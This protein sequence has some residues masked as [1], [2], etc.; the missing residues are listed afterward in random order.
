MRCGRKES[1]ASQVMINFPRR[2]E[3]ACVVKLLCGGP[4]SP[5]AP[6]PLKDKRGNR[7]TR[8]AVGSLLGDPRALPA[9]AL[10]HPFGVGPARCASKGG[11][12]RSSQSALA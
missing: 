12:G 8:R 3:K 1:K 4:S 11:G 2:Q 7:L 9:L 10:L 5:K 6:K